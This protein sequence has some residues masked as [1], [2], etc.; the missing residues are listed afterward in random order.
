MALEL[1]SKI[2]DFWIGDHQKKHDNHQK[3]ASKNE[4]WP[5][6]RFP[7]LAGDRSRSAKLRWSEGTPQNVDARW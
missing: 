2:Q 6:E 4:P 1:L 3:D 5:R 7:F